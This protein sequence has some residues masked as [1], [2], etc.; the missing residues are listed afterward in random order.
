MAMEQPPPTLLFEVLATDILCHCLWKP[1]QIH[2]TGGNIVTLSFVFFFFL[3]A[4]EGA[5]FC[6]EGLAEQTPRPQ[7]CM[8]KLETTGL[9]PVTSCTQP[10]PSFPYRSTW[11]EE[12]SAKS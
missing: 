9:L 10:A 3:L 2:P 6:C 12:G 11:S 5:S 1:N 4:E 8:D 7:L